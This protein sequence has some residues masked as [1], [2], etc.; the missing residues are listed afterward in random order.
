MTL[1]KNKSI[2]ERVLN[3]EYNEEKTQR[4]LGEIKNQMKATANDVSDIKNAIIGSQ[5]NG[6]FGLVHQVNRISDKQEQQEDVLITHKL[7][8]KQIGV[9]I[10]AIITLLVGLVIAYFKK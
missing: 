3:L 9:A 7:Y 8:F 2:D 1:Q 10:G 4:H 5:M 6:N